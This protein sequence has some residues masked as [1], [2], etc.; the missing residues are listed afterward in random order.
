MCK[1]CTHCKIK[2][3][4]ILSLPDMTFQLG[5]VLKITQVRCAEGLWLN[6]FGNSVTRQYQSVMADSFRFNNRGCEYFEGEE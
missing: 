6:E 1:N 3:R 4:D 5:R 2:L